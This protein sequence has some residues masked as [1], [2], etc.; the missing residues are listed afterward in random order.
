[1]QSGLLTRVIKLRS[2]SAKSVLYSSLNN[3]HISLRFS[4]VKCNVLISYLTKNVIECVLPEFLSPRPLISLQC[5]N[6]GRN[7]SFENVQATP[8]Q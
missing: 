8:S 1:M 2:V 3:T 6:I 7:L 4:S 5:G